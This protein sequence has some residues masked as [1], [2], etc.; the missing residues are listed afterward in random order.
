MRIVTY[1]AFRDN[2]ARLESGLRDNP[3]SGGGADGLL[4]S[5]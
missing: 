4:D 3:E 2:R 1:F 5:S